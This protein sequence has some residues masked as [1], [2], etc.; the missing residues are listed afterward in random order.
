MKALTLGLCALGFFFLTNSVY[1]QCGCGSLSYATP[2]AMPMTS[3]APMQPTMPRSPGSVSYVNQ[4]TQPIDRGT[5]TLKYA[6]H[7]TDG[8]VLLADALPPG[9][10]VRGMEY[11]SGGRKMV[12][13]F[14]GDG[15]ITVTDPQ[16]SQVVATFGNASR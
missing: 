12:T 3:Y 1:A 6:I 5:Y 14:A 2:V 7:L 16:S 15:A 13:S 11:Q 8:R 4:L 9:L 10:T